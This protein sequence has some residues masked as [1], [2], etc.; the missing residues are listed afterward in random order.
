[1]ANANS[2]PIYPSKVLT[3]SVRHATANTDRT[4]GGTLT[5]LLTAATVANGGIG[6]VVH[7]IGVVGSAAAGL[8]NAMV[9]R[10]WRVSVGGT[11]TLEDEVAIAASTSST[12]AI[13]TRTQFNRTNI[14]LAPGEALKVTITFSENVDFAA[15]YG[16]Y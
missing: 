9:A 1:M 14:L 16:E 12:T 8:S 2:L 7:R 13:G 15:E 4:G 3:A 5:T 6:A 11:I 10:L